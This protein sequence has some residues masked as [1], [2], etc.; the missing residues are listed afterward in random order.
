MSCG[1]I[2]GSQQVYP[3]TPHQKQYWPFLSIETREYYCA[4]VDGLDDPQVQPPPPARPSWSTLLSPHEIPLRRPWETQ[5]NAH[6]ASTL[7]QDV[8]EV[9][10]DDPL[11]ALYEMNP[12]DTTGLDVLYSGARVDTTVG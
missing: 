1:G 7:V 5:H 4:F 8:V 3:G 6:S 9:F 2:L 11:P 12:A 10:I